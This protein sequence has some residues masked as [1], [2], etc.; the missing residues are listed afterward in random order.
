MKVADVQS[1][2]NILA[3]NILLIHIAMRMCRACPWSRWSV[4]RLHDTRRIIPKTDVLAQAGIVHGCWEV[5]KHWRLCKL[6]MRTSTTTTTA[7]PPV[8]FPSATMLAA[9]SRQNHDMVVGITRSKVIFGFFLVF[10]LA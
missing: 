10:M 2:F 4:T 8:A 6:D 7:I 9:I 1:G 5:Y 3:R